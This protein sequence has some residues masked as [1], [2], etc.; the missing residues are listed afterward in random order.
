MAAPH[1]RDVR[2]TNDEHVAKSKTNRFSSTAAK[3][4]IARTND[5]S[6][7]QYA[8]NRLLSARCCDRLR[9]VPEKKKSAKRYSAKQNSTHKTISQ[10]ELA[11]RL[12]F[13]PAT[14]SLVLSRSGAADS[15]PQDT[16]DLIFGAAQKFNYR[17]NLLA[18]SL[19]TR[20]S[21]TVGVIVPEISEGY[22]ATVL[23]GIE[24]CLLEQHYFFFVTSHRHRAD[25]IEEYPKTFLDRGVDGIIAVDTPWNHKLPVPV[26]TV[27]GH[28][29]VGGV[30]NIVV[31]HRRAS[32]LALAH[33]VELG[34]RKIAFI[35][36]Q[37][38]SSDTEIRWKSNLEAAAR[39]G[40]RILPKLTAQL[41]EDS[42]SPQVGY[43]ATKKLIKSRE[44]FT[45][46]LAFN[47]VSALGAIR[48][49]FEAGLRVPEDVSV[50][51]FDDIQSA[52]FQHP[53]L[54]TIRQ[55]LRKMGKTAAEVVLRSVRAPFEDRH[56]PEIV[57]EPELVIREST[58]ETKSG[59][60][61]DVEARV[62]A[63][64]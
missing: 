9:G 38:F 15:I 53:G 41:E 3:V 12:G 47:D 8:E 28:N 55:P 24:D 20:R 59:N 50:V 39:L 57:V 13:S 36:G 62:P 58:C 35:K 51:G 54:T 22:T 52:E 25:L 45:A 19:R 32:H 27:S 30:T 16:K 60:N 4:L 56:V 33:L 21:F 44:L 10:K 18:R 37:D 43:K 40:I 48:A 11:E 42:P 29:Q 5:D 64:I 6:Q 17:P 34:H 49:L 2:P 31:N 1:T 63:R 7:P 61:V 23:S 46:I 14:V 26:V